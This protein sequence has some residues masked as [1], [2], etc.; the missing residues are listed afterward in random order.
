MGEIRSA[1]DIALEKAANI[2]QDSACAQNR[3]VKN[4]G[5]KAA[6]EFLTNGDSALFEQNVS[7]CSAADRQTFCEGAY[8]VLFAA[9]KLPATFQDIQRFDTAARACAVLCDNPS[10]PDFMQNGSMIL[11]QYMQEK[12]QLKN[13]LAQQYMPKLRQKEQELARLYGQGIHLE[14]EQDPEFADLLR[15]QVQQLSARYTAAI[16]QLLEHLS[17]MTGCTAE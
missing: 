9:V 13:M 15:K 14:P 8:S 6:A 5:I 11:N 1:I 10:L 12:E 16:D 17:L 3:A 4:K 2:Q 7:E